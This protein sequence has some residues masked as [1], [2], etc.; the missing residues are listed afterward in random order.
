MSCGS[1]K[2]YG[3]FC[4]NVV[5]ANSGDQQKF[6]AYHTIEEQAVDDEED[7]MYHDYNYP[8]KSLE[9][10]TG[11]PEDSNF[12]IFSNYYLYAE[13]C[14]GSGTTY[15]PCTN[16][17]NPMTLTQDVFVSSL[18]E[19]RDRLQE[20]SNGVNDICK[21]KRDGESEADLGYRFY[22]LAGHAPDK[23][24]ARH[25]RYFVIGHV[26][27]TQATFTDSGAINQAGVFRPC[28]T[29]DITTGSAAVGIAGVAIEHKLKTGQ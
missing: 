17:A 8:L 14:T 5:D 12:I 20:N 27:L 10:L 24:G 13:H 25:E 7:A 28:A 4:T 18:K 6:L 2:T 19:F 22:E 21:A 11:N 15:G 1:S 16:P 9:P 3:V 29:S 23:P 26:N